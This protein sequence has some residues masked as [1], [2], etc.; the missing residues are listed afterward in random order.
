MTSRPAVTNAG[1]PAIGLT[2][3]GRARSTETLRWPP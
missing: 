2:M 1:K 3:F